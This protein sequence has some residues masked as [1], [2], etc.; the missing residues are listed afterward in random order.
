MIAAYIFKRYSELLLENAGIM[1]FSFLRSLHILSAFRKKSSVK[2]TAYPQPE[3]LH[4][5]QIK[6]VACEKGL[7]FL[8]FS[9]DCMVVRY[10]YK[11]QGR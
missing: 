7:M 5:F 10:T 1:L 3:L 9:T 6:P 2:C 8:D 4:K 11:N